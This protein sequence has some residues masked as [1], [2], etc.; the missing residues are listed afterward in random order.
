MEDTRNNQLL[1]VPEIPEIIELDE[2]LDMAFDPLGI[3]VEIV[4]TNGNCS[5]SQCCND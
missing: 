2:R 4:P 1:P 5:N 3:I